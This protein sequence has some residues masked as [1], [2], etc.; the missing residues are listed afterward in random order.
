MKV[1]LVVGHNKNSMGAKNYL[2]EYEY[3]FN[4]RIA[5]K[6]RLKML[7]KGNDVA[8]IKRTPSNYNTEIEQIKY[9]LSRIGAKV[10]LHLH[11]N[12]YSGKA[13]GCEAL[14]CAGHG[15]DIADKFTDIL[16]ERFGFKE[17]GMDG[18]KRLE[19]GHRGYKMCLALNITGITSVI[20]EPTFANFRNN[21]SKIIFE[22]EDKYVDVIC[23]L[24]NSFKVCD[25][26]NGPYG[27]CSCP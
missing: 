10:S 23:E 8:I 12:S 16:N 22:S 24:I 5:K 17:R 11:F 6:V 4:H 2:G 25:H 27:Q 26:C 14:V 21:E 3:Q 19:H 15:E 7:D 13:K 1:A 18:V 20:L 9:D